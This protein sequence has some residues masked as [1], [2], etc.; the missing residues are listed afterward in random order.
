MAMDTNTVNANSVHREEKKL[1]Q[2]LSPSFTI[3]HT[4]NSPRS[5]KKRARAKGGE[6]FLRERRSLEGA[7]LENEEHAELVFQFGAM[8]AG[9]KVSP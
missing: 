4:L 1:L 6:L 5:S 8:E 7:G 3:G 2:L 9:P